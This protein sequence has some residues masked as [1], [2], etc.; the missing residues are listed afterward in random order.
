MDSASQPPSPATS[1]TPSSVCRPGFEKCP[2]HPSSLV[3][4]RPTVGWP[5]E[6]IHRCPRRF[7][8][9]ELNVDWTEITFLDYIMAKFLELT[10]E[11]R[12]NHALQEL[13]EGLQ[14]FTRKWPE[15]YSDQQVSI[16][17]NRPFISSN[18]HDAVS[19]SDRKLPE[20]GLLCRGDANPAIFTQNNT[21]QANPHH[22]DVSSAPS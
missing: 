12:P 8:E 2:L 5:F 21:H 16:Y 20:P 1:L 10:L 4:C 15:G 6:E 14:I 3:P 7:R 22:E 9:Y 19:I 18:I 17:C 11:E 13:D